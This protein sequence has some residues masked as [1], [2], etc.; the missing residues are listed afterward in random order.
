MKQGRAV[1]T[2]RICLLPLLALNFVVVVLL[3]RDV[4][5]ALESRWVSHQR[6]WIVLVSIGCGLIGPLALWPFARV[7]VAALLLVASIL[8]AN[9]FIR[10]VIVLLPHP[11]HAHEHGSPR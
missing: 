3:F 6:L 2:L 5:G 1:A 11:P 10:Y 9:V 8:A 4:K 7:A